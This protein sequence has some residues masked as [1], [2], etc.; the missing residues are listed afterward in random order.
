M[1]ELYSYSIPFKKPFVTGAGTFNTREGIILRYHDS[2][3][4]VVS[5]AAPL[6]GFSSESLK[7]VKEE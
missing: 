1:F 2:Q 5:E 7:Q 3:I 4:D 6:P